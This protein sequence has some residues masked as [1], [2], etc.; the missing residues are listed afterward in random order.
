MGI[1]LDSGDATFVFQRYFD[2]QVIPLDHGELL[3]SPLGT[4]PTAEFIDSL[5]RADHWKLLEHLIELAQDFYR[6]LGWNVSINVGPFSVVESQDRER[7]IKLMSRAPRG[8]WF[9][10]TH[11]DTIEGSPAVQELHSLIN[12]VGHTAVLDDYVPVLTADGVSEKP[13][14]D[15]VKIDRSVA[16]AASSNLWEQKFPELLAQLHSS[17]DS[18]GLGHVIEGVEDPETF[19]TFVDAGFDVFQGFLFGKPQPV[20]EVLS[21]PRGM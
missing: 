21:N 10:F 2:G 6:L 4:Q 9:E 7:F 3:T 1:S 8:T 17:L 20:T 5:S 14:F 18:A 16:Q 12:K 11:E 15:V 13:S 19:R